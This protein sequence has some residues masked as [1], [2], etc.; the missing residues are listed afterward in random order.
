MEYYT[1][2][3]EDIIDIDLSTGTIH[4]S[5]MNHIL[6]EGDAKENRYGVRVFRNGEPVSLSMCPIIGYFMRSDGTSV[7]IEG[8]A[9]QGNVCYVTLPAACYAVEGQFTLAIKVTGGGVIGTMRIVDGT[10]VSTAEG[11][12]VD[13]GS[14]IPDLSDYASM[15]SQ[16]E[17]IAEEISEIVIENEQ[18]VGTRYRIKVTTPSD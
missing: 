9:T 16:A 6:G 15:V 13:P 17:N 10:V 12:L 1:H 2:Y 18:I 11:T 3:N 5:F 7:V 8:V 4:R 14:V